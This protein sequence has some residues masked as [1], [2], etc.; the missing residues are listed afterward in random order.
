[1]GWLWGSSN[2]DAV[3][4]PSSEASDIAKDSTSSLALT[5]EQRMR[6]FGR[7]SPTP[8]S[9]PP[10][11][12]REQQADSELEAFLKEIGASETTTA[13]PSS[14]PLTPAEPP[15]PLFPDRVRPDGTLDISPEAIYPRTMSCRA[16]FD[17]AFYCQS[18][19]G[20]FN[21]IYRYGHLRQCSEQ[22]GAF[23]F[24]MRTRTL[25]AHQKEKAISEHYAAR[26]QRRKEEANSEDVWELRTTAVTEAFQ[27]N[28]DG[29]GENV[30]EGL[31]GGV[32]E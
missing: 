11:T 23:W 14:S 1:M 21:D 29:D 28:P 6:I 7:P 8:Q 5:E 17:Q 20:K 2:G 32:K 12:T 9:S 18:I 19:G 24:C 27:R 25:P 10:T 13:N 22:W 3:N 4:T 16:A 26:D 31:I 15:K 30:G